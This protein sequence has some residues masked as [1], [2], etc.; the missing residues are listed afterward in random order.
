[1]DSNPADDGTTLEVNT[2]NVEENNSRIPIPYV[3]PPGVV[4]EQLNNNNTIIRQNEQSLSLIVD[5]LE[6]QDARGVFKNLNIDVR[7]YERIKMFMHA[8]KIADTDYADTATP[9]VGFLRI[10]TDFTQNYY[11]IEMPLQFTPFGASAPEEIWPEGN[12][13][14]VA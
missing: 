10:G 5:N 7:Q 4:R 9:L 8:E 3:L 12:E 2:V 13:L 1:M 11:Q 6:P 14:D